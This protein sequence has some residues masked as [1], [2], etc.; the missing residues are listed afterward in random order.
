MAPTKRAAKAQG[1]RA[2]KAPRTDPVGARVDAVAGALRRAP[3]EVVPAG[4]RAMLCSLVDGACR[5]AAGERHEYQAKVVAMLEQ[6]LHR[7]EAHLQKEVEVA[8]AKVDG[9]SGD[10]AAQ[11]EALELAASKLRDSEAAEAQR[12]EALAA[13]KA[14]HAAKV[15][16]LKGQRR[17]QAEVDSPFLA[18]SR[19][20]DSMKKALEILEAVKSASVD[21][22]MLKAMLDT[23]KRFNVDSSLLGSAIHATKK[24]PADRGGFDLVVLG[25]L[26]EA[27][28]KLAEGLAATMASGEP[29]R[30]EAAAATAA[31]EAAAGSTEAAVSAAAELVRSVAEDVRAAGAAVRAARKAAARWL[32]DAKVVMDAYDALVAQAAEL[33]GVLGDFAALKE[34]APEPEPMAA[35]GPEP[36]AA[37]PVAAEGVEVGIEASAVLGATDP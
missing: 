9:V 5:T 18:T 35:E 37:E 29:A 10:K 14:E 24:E 22:K 27:F 13:A 20:V 11:Q 25:N 32:P 33:A 36:V 12:R 6:T 8:K 28:A 19:D 2:A 16:E 1:G 3:E 7:V 34:S 30:A 26:E 15:E 23:G 17:A 4:T 21:S 31:M